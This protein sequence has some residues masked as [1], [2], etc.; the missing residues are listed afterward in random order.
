MTVKPNDKIVDGATKWVVR[1]V[2]ANS[3]PVGTIIAMTGTTMPEGYLLCDGAAVSR[4]D[5]ADLFA[6][7]DTLYGAGDGTTTFNLPNLSGGCMLQGVVAGNIGLRLE[8]GLPNV[9]GMSTWITGGVHS[10]SGGFYSSPELG[11]VPHI[12]TTLN[13][14]DGCSAFDMSR[15][16]PIYGAS[17]TVQP[18]ALNVRFFIKY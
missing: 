11:S 3:V 5:Y 8:P 9:Y 14:Y 18:R 16:N 15:V 6:V 1:D 13:G 2:R 4:T 12:S 7:C 10:L 17:D